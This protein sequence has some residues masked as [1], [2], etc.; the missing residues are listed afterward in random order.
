[1]ETGISSSTSCQEVKGLEGEFSHMANDVINHI[2]I[3][4]T[5]LTT[6]DLEVP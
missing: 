6:P 5:L 1:M 3:K 4:K 2:Y